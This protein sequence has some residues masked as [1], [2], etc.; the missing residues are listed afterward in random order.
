MSKSTFFHIMVWAIILG[1][2][3]SV[4]Y[5][6]YNEMVEHETAKQKCN[7]KGGTYVHVENQGNRCVKMIDL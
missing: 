6:I 4:A 1:V 7:Q 3:G 2:A 5:V